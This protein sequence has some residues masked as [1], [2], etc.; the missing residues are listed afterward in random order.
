M[1]VKAGFGGHARGFVVTPLVMT[2]FR[3]VHRLRYLIHA[4]GPNPSV[5]TRPRSDLK[6]VPEGGLSSVPS[7][8]FEIC[9][10]VLSTP[11]LGPMPRRRELTGLDR[12]CYDRSQHRAHVR[13][14]AR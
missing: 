10:T 1:T 4:S 14:A 2:C 8:R 9:S 12:R 5:P 6:R 13:F 3:G 7:T 11:Q